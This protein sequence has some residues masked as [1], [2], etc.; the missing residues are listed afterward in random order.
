MKRLRR[1][2]GRED[3]A[4]DDAGARGKADGTASPEEGDAPRAEPFTLPSRILEKDIRHSVRMEAQASAPRSWPL[5]NT[6]RRPEANGAQMP[7]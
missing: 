6:C 4:T 5:E 1:G 7:N 2:D 3:R